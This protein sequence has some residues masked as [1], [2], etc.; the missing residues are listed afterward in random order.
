M[1][2][3]RRRHGRALRGVV[4]DP[5][6]R[7]AP[8]PRARDRQ[9]RQ[10]EDGARP[11]HD[12]PDPAERLADRSRPRREPARCGRRARSDG[13]RHQLPAPS[14]P[15][16]SSARLPARAP[17]PTS[18][19]TPR[20]RTPARSTRP[21]SPTGSTTCASSRPTPPA[22]RRQLRRRSRCAIDN[23]APDR[24]RHRAERRRERPRH[25]SRS[26]ATPPIPAPASPPS[27]SSAHPPAPAPG[28]TRP[29]LRHHHRSPTA[30]TTSASPPPTTPATPSPPP[31]SPIR[32][33]NTLP[34]GAVTA[35]T[36]GANVRGTIALTSDSADAGSGVA[37][38]QFQRSPAGTGTWT[39][40][41]ASFD[42]TTLTDGQYDLRVTTTDN[43]GNP[44]TS[45]AIT[46]RVD[47]TLPTGSI[48]APATAAR[49]ASRR[50]R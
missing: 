8:A 16:A 6:R 33:D 4:A 27:S 42:T 46:I 37:T 2:P 28:R 21:R 25:R 5:V 48:T 36:A 15:S 9:R 43:A 10:A 23:T 50:W 12:R 20:R 35:P 47:N 19:P 17:G 45:A 29:R 32:V 30:S 34:T 49:S 14:T 40:Q 7:A 18:R 31:R 1:G 44:F 13:D 41:T 24:H 11:D 3:A 38:V 39:N 22:T 26:P